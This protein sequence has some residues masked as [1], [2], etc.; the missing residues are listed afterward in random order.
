MRVVS[1]THNIRKCQNG[2]VLTMYFGGR[3]SH[4]FYP[5]NERQAKVDMVTIAKLHGMSDDAV[6]TKIYNSDFRYHIDLVN[7]DFVS[8]APSEIDPR[9]LVL[10]D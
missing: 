9:C 8:L 7:G 10:T 5:E 3:M 6:E 1:N 2:I 4:R